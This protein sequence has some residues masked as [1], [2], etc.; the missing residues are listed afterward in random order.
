MNEKWFEIIE[1]YLNGE[2]S[3]EERLRFEAELNENEALSSV[4]NMYRTIEEDMRSDAT[5][6]E[7]E[8]S[9]RHTLEALNKKYASGKQP[10]TLEEQHSQPAPLMPAIDPPGIPVTGE[11]RTGVIKIK[12]WKK[13]AVA[14][15]VTGII[16]IGTTWFLQ[17]A[18]ESLEVATANG[19]KSDTQKISIDPDTTSIPPP[20]SRDISESNKNSASQHPDGRKVPG[21]PEQKQV[22][23]KQLDAIYTVHAKPD[24]LPGP[25]ERDIALAVEEE[26]Y[27]NGR[28]KEAI[29]KYNDII[30]RISNTGISTR[31]QE[32]EQIQRLLFYA[33][34]YK[35]QSYLGIDSAAKAISP[36]DKAIKISPD[37]YWKSK[38]Q[39]YLALTYLG[40]GQLQKTEALLKHL[41]N[42]NR[43]GDYQQKAKELMDT[44]SMSH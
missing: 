34:Y 9:F 8:I 14:A 44:L 18:N 6:S 13:L 16:A 4:F 43:A 32:D 39:W 30:A 27:E 5:N 41:V 19:I 40:T 7:E 37:N 26:Y 21:L 25:A 3:R 24:T 31:G 1:D 2:M 15:A 17:T 28:Y 33:Y 42:N 38:A 20:F 10:V 29:S 22:N 12:T 35:A 23:R 36:L 11:G